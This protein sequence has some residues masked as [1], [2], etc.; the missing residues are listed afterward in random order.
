MSR[1]IRGQSGHFVFP[2]SPK[3]TNFVE[4]VEILLPVKF[5]CRM[6]S[7]ATHRDHFVRRLS[8]RL[9]HFSVTLS[10]AIFRRRHMHSSEC[11][12]Y[13]VEFRSAVSEKS[14]MFQPFRGQGGNLVFPNGPKNKKLVEDVDILLPVK[15]R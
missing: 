13:I 9:S 10:K 4:D 15:F 11:C 7:I 12:H 5:L 3:N 6:R 8:V 14:K 2:I 1:S